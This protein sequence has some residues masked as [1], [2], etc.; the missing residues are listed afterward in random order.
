[1]KNLLPEVDLLEKYLDFSCIIF[2]NGNKISGVFN[3]MQKNQK[4][5]V[6]VGVDHLVQLDLAV[7]INGLINAVI[8]K[9]LNNYKT[10]VRPKFCKLPATVP[11]M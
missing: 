10:E 11:Q 4:R 6:A 8:T 5:C 9:R 7:I 2:S 1:M 3:D